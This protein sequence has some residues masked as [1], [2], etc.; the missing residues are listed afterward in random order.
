M[1]LNWFDTS[2]VDAFAD[3]L[4]SE[5]CQRVT[6]E[7][8]SGKARGGKGKISEA[9]SLMFNRLARFAETKRPN[10][11]KRARLANTIKWL[12]LDRSFDKGFVDT[13]SVD[14]AKHI[15][16]IVKEQKRLGKN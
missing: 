12:L 14:V 2:E 1:F 4:I 11:F 15:S 5:F 13:L 6:P 16:L 3:S 10:L 8:F 9:Q 7:H